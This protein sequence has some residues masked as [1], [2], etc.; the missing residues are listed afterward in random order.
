[1]QKKLLAERAVICHLLSLGAFGVAV[2]VVRGLAAFA[3]SGL[4]SVAFAC[5]V[6]WRL[7]SSMRAHTARTLECLDLNYKN[8]GSPRFIK[9]SQVI[10]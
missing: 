5:F 9:E 3:V 2:Q 1:M 4:A 6:S 10:N 8:S 7:A